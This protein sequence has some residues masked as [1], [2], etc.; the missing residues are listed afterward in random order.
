MTS[1]ARTFVA[2]SV[3]GALAGLVG[4]A[5]AAEPN[6]TGQWSWTMKRPNQD[7]EIK[8]TLKLKQE[9]EK[10]TGMMVTPRG[11]TEIEDGKVEKGGAISFAITRERNGEKHVQKYTGKVQG[12]TLNLET[13]YERNGEK[14]TRKIEAKREGEKV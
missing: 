7:Q 3:L 6:A 12:D 1:R 4:V 8:L 2:L 5:Q 11:E 14:Q 13:E 9:G 10:L